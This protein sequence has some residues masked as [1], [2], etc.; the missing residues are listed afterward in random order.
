MI[1]SPDGERVGTIRMPERLQP[2]HI[3]VDAAAGVR[4]NAVGVGF[5]DVHSLERSRRYIRLRR[6]S[7]RITT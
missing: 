5:V 6:S 3:T 2:T 4:R 7:P 1:L